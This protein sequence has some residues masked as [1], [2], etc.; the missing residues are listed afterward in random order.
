MKKL[1]L[2]VCLFFIVGLLYSQPETPVFTIGG[3]KKE[4]K[5]EKSYQGDKEE[6]IVEPVKEKKTQKRDTI[7]DIEVPVFKFGKKEKKK[8]PVKVYEGDKE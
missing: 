7:K 4:T 3:K 5:K 2:F 6:E 8:K 1:V